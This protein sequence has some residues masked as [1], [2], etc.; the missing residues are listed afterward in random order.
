MPERWGSPNMGWSSPLEGAGI[1]RLVA[2]AVIS[3]RHKARSVTAHVAL[4]PVI[5]AF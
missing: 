3:S 2:V 5:A 1:S 4:L